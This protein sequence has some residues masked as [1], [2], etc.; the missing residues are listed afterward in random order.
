MIL[1]DVLGVIALILLFT[2][3]MIVSPML[4]NKKGNKKGGMNVLDSMAR[5]IKEMVNW[6]NRQ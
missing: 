6:M 1:Q 4:E 2:A 5:K 3:Y